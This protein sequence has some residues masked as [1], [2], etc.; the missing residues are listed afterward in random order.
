MA[1]LDYCLSLITPKKQ[2]IIHGI[3]AIEICLIIVRVMQKAYSHAIQKSECLISD[4]ELQLEGIPVQYKPIM[5][6]SSISP[7]GSITIPGLFRLL[8][9][10]SE[11]IPVISRPVHD[12]TFPGTE[13]M[14]ENLSRL[15]IL[16]S[17]VRNPDYLAP[18]LAPDVLFG[19]EDR[20]T[21]TLRGVLES[22]KRG[23]IQMME[24]FT[25][26]TAYGAFCYHLNPEDRYYIRSFMQ[27]IAV[28]KRDDLDDRTSVILAV[29]ECNRLIIGYIFDEFAEKA[30]K[31][32]IFVQNI[33][34]SLFGTHLQYADSPFG[35]L[36]P[37]YCSRRDPA[38]AS[39]K[40]S[41]GCEQAYPLVTGSFQARSSDEVM[42][43][44][45]DTGYHISRYLL[46]S[47]I[48]RKITG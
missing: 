48:C 36:S 1:D 23:L 24:G 27:G 45:S 29:R 33:T 28:T 13:E 32:E 30:L 14:K 11:Q 17:T 39:S 5:N 22:I 19:K 7:S 42:Q 15:I 38:V 8:D 3:A 21:E 25:P 20:K 47:F 26:D 41:D 18:G 4:E 35:L 44:L 46:D 37:V 43:F 31:I 6:G 10:I 40:V 34:V 2:H 16:N 12:E 9:Q